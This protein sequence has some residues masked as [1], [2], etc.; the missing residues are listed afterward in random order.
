MRRRQFLGVL[1]GAAATWPLAARAQE[2][3]KVYRIGFFGPAQTS[4]P[5]IAFYQA[6]LAQMRELGFREG[7][8]LRVEFRPL[9][10]TR[11]ISVSASELIRSQPELIVV[12][13]PAIALQSIL[14][15]SQAFPI[16]MVAINFDPIA[17]GHVKSLARPG[18]NITGVVFQQL[19]LAQKQVELL[20]QAVPGMTRV[21]ILFEAQTAD[22]LGAAER[23]AKSLKLQVQP[24]K[25][26]SPS[27]DFDGAIR[28]AA[29][30]GAQMMLVLSGPGF[31]QHRSRIAE[32]AIQHR[33][34]TMFIAKHYA[35]AGGLISY[36]ADF[37]MMF[38]KAADHVAKILKGAKPADLPV[39]QATKFEM[40][41][42]LKTAKAIGVELPT[43]ILLRADQVI[44]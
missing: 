35:E 37:S 5:P 29:A 28:S 9:E 26:E 12:T 21:A 24:L 23:A 17:G 1:G 32:L 31:T 25:L 19:E 27:Y 43:S 22:Q 36:G 18:G 16:V 34:P 30:A 44:E 20:T 41:L 38:R 40:V 8:N 15:T 6:F 33:L 2:V 7:Q 42:N 11:G 4:P 39:E 14:G 13:G 3:G 10:D